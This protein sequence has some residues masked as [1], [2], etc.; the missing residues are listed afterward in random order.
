MVAQG[1]D[2]RWLF[3]AVLME[4]RQVKAALKAM[5]IKTDRRNAEGIARLLQMGWFRPVHCKTVS[6]QEMRALLTSRKSV[7]TVLV[8][9]ELSLRGVLRNFGLK[10]GQVSKGRYEARVRDLIAG[11]AM[12]EAAAEPILRARIPAP[13]AGWPGEA[14]PHSGPGG[15]GLWGADDHAR[16][17]P[18]VALTFVSAIDDPGRFRRSK[19]AGPWVGLTPGRHQSG[20][21]DIVG[22]ITRAGDA[23]LHTALSGRDGDAEPGGPELAEG[24]GA[25]SGNAPRQEARNGR[26]GPAHRSGASPDVAGRHRVPLHAQGSD[27]ASYGIGAAASHRQSIRRG[28]KPRRKV[29]SH[30]FP[31]AGTRFP[32]MHVGPLVCQAAPWRSS[33]LD[34]SALGNRLD[35]A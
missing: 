10:L 4:T 20:Q 8:N 14:G 29:A 34:R 32:M 30:R 33:T 6:S 2:R 15:S 28:G 24:V 7:Q 25:A 27:G 35:Q 11:N 26:A 13:R 3:E 18:G 21:R 23:G 22:A 1:A 31:L 16:R 19:D 17:R 5:P 12:L 9:L